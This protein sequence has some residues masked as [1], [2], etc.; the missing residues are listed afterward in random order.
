M[1]LLINGL[2]GI[3]LLAGMTACSEDD[4]DNPDTDPEMNLPVVGSEINLEVTFAGAGAPYDEGQQALFRFGTNGSLGIDLNPAA[5]DG[6]EVS[7]VSY[8][9]VGGEYIWTDNTA[10]IKYALSLTADDSIN[11]VNVFDL[12]ENFLNQWTPIQEG[13]DNLDLIINAFG[14]YTVNNVL[15]GSHSR[16]IVNI[17]INGN[18]DFD[19]GVSFSTSE[20]ALITD[21]LAANKQV[22]VDIDPYPNDPYPRL[23][24]T[25]DG[26]NN[27]TVKSILYYPQYPNVSGRTEVEF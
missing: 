23:E 14:Q 25:Y 5:A 24:L 9:E 26:V 3:F 18:I 20:Y 4:D 6:N 8:N 2:L 7:V 17:D 12:N 27:T 22:Y 13:D 19:D 21:R 10:S 15:R 1:K 16:M 11:E